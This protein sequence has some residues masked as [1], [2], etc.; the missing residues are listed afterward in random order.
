MI[1]LI[2]QL[3]HSLILWKLEFFLYPELLIYPYLTTQKLLPYSQI[4]DQHFPGLMFFPINFFSLG[5]TDPTSFKSLLVLIVIFQSV[6]IYRLTKS[7][8]AVLLFTILHPLFEGN[9]LWLDSFLPLLLLPAYWS[10]TSKRFFMTGLL[11]GLGVVFKQTLVPAVVFIGLILLFKKQFKDLVVF[12]LS[13]LF[14]SVLMLMYMGK[15][16]ILS[17]F[18]YWT[19]Q[20]NL[21]TFAAHGRNLPTPKEVIKV[22]F[23]GVIAIY[24]FVRYPKSRHGLL[25]GLM[26]SLE[27]FS[28]FGLIHLQTFIPFLAIAVSYI[29]SLKKLFLIFFIS[30]AWLIYFLL[31]QQNIGGYKFFDPDTLTIISKVQENT[32]P[33]DTI[34]LLGV[35]PHI[36]EQTKTLPPGNVFVFQFPWFLQISGDRILQTLKDDPPKLILYNPESEIDEQ[37]LRDYAHYLVEYTVSNYRLVDE[38]GVTQIY[39]RRN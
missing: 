37:Y 13:A 29:K 8:S 9:Q 20:F 35:Q 19:V 3:I 15:I 32:D 18:W 7:K 39:A 25:L 10:F 24:C 26:A 12:S 28:R 16:G 36:Y 4:L 14:P 6:F 11:L 31:R 33:G 17:D 27:T 5:F 22:S 38:V 34:F 2:F 23:V 21:T 30:I 1:V